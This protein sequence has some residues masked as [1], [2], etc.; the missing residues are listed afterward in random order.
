[1]SVNLSIQANGA[2]AIV[3]VR[4]SLTSQSQAVFKQQI[5]PVLVN[6]SISKIKLDFAGLQSIE[7]ASSG[8]LMFL[9]H[10]AKAKNKSLGVVNSNQAVLAV[11]QKA[12]LGKV[13]DIIFD[14]PATA[15]LRR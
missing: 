14:Q 12:N 8:M 7:A 15:A 10:A 13:L 3:I 1:M 4:G 5:E 6:P 2:L 11:M 9:S